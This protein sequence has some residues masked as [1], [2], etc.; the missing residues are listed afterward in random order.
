MPQKCRAAAGT[1]KR[2]WLLTA[3]LAVI[4]D[5]DSDQAAGHANVQLDAGCNPNARMIVWSATRSR[6][7]TVASPYTVDPWLTA[8]LALLALVERS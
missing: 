5:D 7:S 4:G 3:K 2:P 1:C 8:T 6:A